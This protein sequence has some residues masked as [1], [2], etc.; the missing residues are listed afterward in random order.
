MSHFNLILHIILIFLLPWM[1]SPPEE[2]DFDLEV[3]YNGKLLPVDEVP[4][5]E[6]LPGDVFTIELRITPNFDS[7]ISLGL[8]GTAP[9]SYKVLSGPSP[10]E[11]TV[12]HRVKARETLRVSWIDSASVIRSPAIIGNAG[13]Y[14]SI[15]IGAQAPSRP[16]SRVRASRPGM[17]VSLFIE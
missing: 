4:S 10:W 7:V 16:S 17:G 12:L 6:L 2:P 13:R 15:V 5:P 1:G 14:R 8:G 9:G 3:L 11:K